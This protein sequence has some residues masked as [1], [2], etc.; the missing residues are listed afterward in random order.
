MYGAAFCLLTA[1]LGFDVGWQPLEDGGMEYIIQIEPHVL[2][3]LKSGE[4]LVSDIPPNLRGVR[5]YRIVVGTEKLP[6]EGEMP[7]P[8]APPSREV[9]LPAATQFMPPLPSP[10]V[11]T[12]PTTT[13]GS[14][15]GGSLPQVPA[16]E[17][18]A[19][20][21]PP[22]DTRPLTDLGERAAAF[23]PYDVSLCFATEAHSSR[24]CMGLS[25]FLSTRSRH[26]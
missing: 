10:V 16:R 22:T 20:L 9:R 11:Q 19:T 5:S 24:R 18:P 1:T 21:T 2:E 4:Q 15:G 17:V 12:G 6:R 26:S 23:D 25:A 13:E 3:M 14:P 8:E 7:E